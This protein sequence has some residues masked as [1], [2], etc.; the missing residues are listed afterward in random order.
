MILHFENFETASLFAAQRRSEGYF[1]RTLDSNVSHF[2]G[3]L[4]VIGSR[5]V[6]S[7]EPIDED[8]PSSPPIIWSRYFL[9]ALNVLALAWM[10]LGALVPLGFILASAQSPRHIT[11]SPLDGPLPAI[12]AVITLCPLVSLFMIWATREDR[13]RAPGESLSPPMALIA[14]PLI[15]NYCDLLLYL[16]IPFLIS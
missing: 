12:L 3:P 7:E 13:L 9:P 2:W 4:P 5:V 6:V 16:L 1:A 11:S 15:L 14:I 10:L 8:A